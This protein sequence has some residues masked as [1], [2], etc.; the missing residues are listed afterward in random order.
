MD[1]L[2]TFGYVWCAVMTITVIILFYRADK[3]KDDF[4]G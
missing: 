1:N 4:Q 2:S 3:N